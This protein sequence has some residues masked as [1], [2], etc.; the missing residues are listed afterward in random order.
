MKLFVSPRSPFVREVLIAVCELGLAASIERVPVAVRMDQPND[1][2]LAIN[3]LGK[4]P[5]LILDDGSAVSGAL[6]I[7][8]ELDRRAGGSL[9]PT[10]RTERSWHLRHQAIS[11]GLLDILVLWR[12][13][14]DKPPP[15]QTPGW[16]ANF[17]V[18][19][20][21]TLD[22]LERSVT[23][24]G[25]TPFGLAHVSLAALVFYLDFRFAALE[26]RGSRPLLAEWAAENGNR[27]SVRE[28]ATLCDAM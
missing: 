22:A 5:T 23:E 17:E 15:Q 13:E 4:I 20:A 10:D 21:N 18:K 14:R 27:A 2:V 9:L 1:T 16:L 6:T 19:T 7:I 28:A 11:H 8:D 12:N 25:V 26:W 24:V 3:P